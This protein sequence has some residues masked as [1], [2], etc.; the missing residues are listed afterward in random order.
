MDLRTLGTVLTAAV[1][2]AATQ[3]GAQQVYKCQDAAGK[4]TKNSYGV[5]QL[6]WRAAEDGDGGKRVNEELDEVRQ[7]IKQT[8]K[9][10]LRFLIWA[11]MGGSASANPSQRVTRPNVAPGISALITTMKNTTLNRRWLPSTCASTGMVAKT[12]GTA[13][14]KP[15][16][17]M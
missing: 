5:F 1:A 6:S 11:G 17:P 14:R 3:A 2:F 15:T 10:R 12:I 9:A 13:P 8:H 7:G 16:Q 4:V